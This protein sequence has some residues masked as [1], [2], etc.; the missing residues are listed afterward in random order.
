MR[1]RLVVLR[2]IHEMGERQV[3]QAAICKS[4]AKRRESVEKRL[5]SGLSTWLAVLVA[6]EDD[7]HEIKS[8]LATGA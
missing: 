6:V 3:R 4:V 5:V 8:A 2:V 1:E 7:E